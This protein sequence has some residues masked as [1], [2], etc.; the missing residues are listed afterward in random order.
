LQLAGIA[1]SRLFKQFV[2]TEQLIRDDQIVDAV[3]AAGQCRFNACALLL[4]L[5]LSAAAL[6]V[7]VGAGAGVA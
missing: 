1:R 5:T 7:P 2:E 3:L 6:A 4:R